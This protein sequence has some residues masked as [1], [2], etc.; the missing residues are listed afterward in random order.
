M[1]IGIY[2]DDHREELTRKLYHYI[3]INQY[4]F[5]LYCK[6][7]QKVR[8]ANIAKPQIRKAKR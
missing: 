2:L 6:F 5:I 1:G 3:Q 4:H 7:L 8:P